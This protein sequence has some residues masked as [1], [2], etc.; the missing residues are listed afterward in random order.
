LNRKLVRDLAG[1]K[2]QVGAI[3]AVVALGIIMFA[4]PLMAQRSLRRSIDTIRRKTNYE[5]F[6][7]SMGN[8]P[9][10]AAAQV[11]A[12][13]DVTAVQGRYVT[14][15]LGEVNGKRITIR[16]IS[17]PAAGDPSVNGLLM[18][19]GTMP[20]VGSSSFI[21]EHHL[22]D[23]FKLKPGDS[24]K[25][26]L[27]GGPTKL[28]MSGSAVSPEYLRLVRSRAEYVTDPSQFGVVFVRIPAVSTIFN[29]GGSINQ[30]VATTTTADAAREAMKQAEVV[31]QPYGVTEVVAGADEPGTVTLN[32]EITDVGKIAIFFSILLLAVASLALYITMTQIVYAQQG[33]IGVTRALG[34]NRVDVV[35]HYT[36]FGFVMGIA[37]GVL[38]VIAGYLM[39]ILFI[40]IYSGIFDL[41]LAASSFS[42]WIAFIGAGAALVFSVAGALLPARHAA[43]MK[44][45]EAMRQAAGL[46]LTGKH[47][48]KKRKEG[49][50]VLPTWL[51][52]AIR[53]LSRNRRRTLLTAIGIIATLTLLVTASGGR[54]SLDF[55][56]SKYL[57]G[58]LRW[59]VA[60]VWS[61][62]VGQSELAA[63]RATPGVTNAEEFIDVPAAISFSGNELDVQLQ[64]FR[65]GT[66]MHG[67]YPV[68]GKA[69]PGDGQIVL[70]WGA[71]KKLPVKLGDPV[72]VKTPVG[73]LPFTVAGFVSE[74][75]GGVAYVDLGYVQRVA[76]LTTGKPGQFNGVVTRTAPGQSV[77]VADRL[78]LLPGVYQVATKSLILKVFQDLVDAVK[79]LFFIFYIMAF[80]M[81]FAVLFSMITV[82]LFERRRE[83]AT[84][85]TLGAGW[86]L[87]FSFVTVETVAIVIASIIPG[88]LLGR[89]L[90][91]FIIGQIVM[92]ERL[93]P[94]SVIS[95]VTLLVIVL[96]TLAVMILSELPS[97]S[98]LF[99]ID[100]SRA[101]KEQ[102]Y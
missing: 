64:A 19:A 95:G 22:T 17:L 56:V 42:I 101:T 72:I 66:K 45:A 38:G 67:K 44:P 71:T 73:T 2:V 25:L 11:K 18:E 75:F 54:D 84:V 80:A 92:S 62:Q 10:T 79:T 39:S 82:I 89:L 76:A 1:H 26:L 100:L 90:E 78:S 74:P 21:A 81:G 30:V 51:R 24:I 63:V 36:G 70:N 65:K 98:R 13:P 49:K 93:A 3:I 58:V 15:V 9:P 102:S 69:V 47:K 53:N 6:S 52:V 96:A 61:R 59:D 48:V 91:W 43:R 60:V 99:K 28:V 40:S 31:L 23:Q 33:Q 88:I 8:A 16:V 86:G 83:I 87:V 94:D 7:A 29:T 46:A 37:G 68:K 57:H 97:L 14:D 34:Y 77:K 20:P 55:A 4:G 12:I 5:D 32:K 50:P 35:A 85:R 41:P 27:P